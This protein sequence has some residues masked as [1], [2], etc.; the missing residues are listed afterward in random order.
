VKKFK[1]QKHRTRIWKLWCRIQS[2]PYSKI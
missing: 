1:L 2:E